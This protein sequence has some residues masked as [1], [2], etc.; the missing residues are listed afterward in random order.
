MKLRFI[1]PQAPGHLN[2]K[3]AQ[4]PLKQYETHQPN[5]SATTQPLSK[6]ALRTGDLDARLG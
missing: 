2:T 4:H 1:C 6:N 5:G 3:I